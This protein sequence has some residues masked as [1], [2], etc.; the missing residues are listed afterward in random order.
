M[1]RDRIAKTEAFLQDT[2][3]QNVFCMNNSHREFT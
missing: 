1:D 2:F 3:G